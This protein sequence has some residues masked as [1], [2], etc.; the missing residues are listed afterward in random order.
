MFKKSGHATKIVSTKHELDGVSKILLPGMGS[1]DNCMS[2]FN[3]S[4]L[5]P[6]IEQMVFAQKV[7]LL[8]ICV[9]LQMFMEGSEEGRLSGLGWIPGKTIRF[10]EPSMSPQLK[11]PN[12]GWLDIHAAKPSRLLNGLEESRFYFA[13]SFHVK[14]SNAADALAYADYGYRFTVA[15]ERD[16]IMGVQFHPEKS[17][18]FGLQ[19]LKNFAE[20]Y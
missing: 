9:G 4:E 12:M 15:I 19:L 3:G 20:N 14:E 5:K 18:K 1:F 6:E 16:N 8:G 17:H 2:K 13:H 7:P 11:V 10:K